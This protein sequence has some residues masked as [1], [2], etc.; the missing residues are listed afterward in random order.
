YGTWQTNLGRLAKR[1][2][3]YENN[4]I[5]ASYQTVRYPL[6]LNFGYF[7]LP[8]GPVVQE[9]SAELLNFIKKHLKLLAK[10]NKVVFVRLDFTPTLN[11][12][13]FSLAPKYTY[14]SAYFQPRY[15]WVLNLAPTPDKL[16]ENMDKD[17]RYSIR[18]AEKKE[19][20]TEIV[21]NNF[22]KYF[23]RF[24]ELMSETAQRNNFSLHSEK[25]YRNIFAN[26]SQI[27]NSY[28]SI[29]KYQEKILAI[30]VIIVFKGVANYVY[31]ASSNEER[32]RAPAYLAQWNGILKAKQLGCH[33]YN[34]GG[35]SGSD[36]RHD[37]WEGLTFFKKNFDGREIKHSDFSDLIINNFWYRLYCARKLFQKI[38]KGV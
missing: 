2:L 24:Y 4:K 16:L 33:S 5:V 6:W 31:A 22:S 37:G 19:I 35:I 15:E 7:Y 28:L 17:T 32:N 38:K 1:F 34:F 23:D 13:I 10:Q 30:N 36:D 8:Y 9:N 21:T 25:Y 29:A 3:V 27:N 26:L 12:K 11:Q 14:H 20:I 18:L